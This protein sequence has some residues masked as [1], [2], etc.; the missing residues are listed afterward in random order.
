LRKVE[1]LIAD[2]T[3]STP[4]RGDTSKKSDLPVDKRLWRSDDRGGFD[5]SKRLEIEEFQYDGSGNLL[6]RNSNVRGTRHFKYGKGDKLEQLEKIR[7]VYDAVGNLIQKLRSDGTLTSYEY[8][9]DN[10][11]TVVSTESGGRVEFRYD[12]FGRRT[13]KITNEGTTDY[14]WDGSALLCEG[15]I[16][17]RPS[18]EYVHDGHVPLARIRE[19]AVQMYHTDFFGTPKEVSDESG[20][21]VWQGTYDEYGRLI[22]TKDKTE[23]NI[24]FQGQYEDA[25]T[26]LYYN[27]FRYYDPDA[28]RYINQDPIA[29]HGGLNLYG[30]G[31][32][33][34]NWVDELGL[35]PAPANLPDTDGIYIITNGSDSYVG[36]S[37]I[38]NQGMNTRT[39]S[40]THKSAQTLL[41]RSGTK[42]QYVEIFGLSNVTASGGRTADGNRNVILRYYEQKQLD[43][44]A[45][46]KNM[47]NGRKS[48]G[49]LA[50]ILSPE[51]MLEAEALIKK[52]GI[53]RSDRRK[54]C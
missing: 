39:S 15:G 31:L 19:G 34:V 12:A 1:R 37:G 52:H 38:G 5:V 46:S 25:E 24:R 10:Q 35:V 20:E 4:E 32:N 3:L 26:G 40:S 2:S 13:T 45:R 28:C 36:S 11:L 6:E 47:L 49:T 8:D 29:L 50:R 43:Y 41:K 48:D 30:Y 23:Q 14:L 17:H 54:T 33:P 18:L 9:P 51:V 44:Q 7:Y 27:H 53:T 16:S 21:I 22:A 42:V